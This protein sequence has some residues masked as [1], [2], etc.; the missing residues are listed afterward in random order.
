MELARIEAFLDAYFEGQSTLEQE[1]QLREYFTTQEVAP[2]LIA[3]I[4]LFEGLKAAQEEVLEK[5]VT[6]PSTTTFSKR[7]WLSIAASIVIV[8]GVAGL[9]FSNSNQLTEEEVIALAE[10]NKSKE[11]LLLLSKS[12][13]KGTAEL[14]ALGEFTEAKNKIIK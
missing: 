6:L 10:F 14:A 2:H 4:G 13:N 8:L 9:Q 12:F 5:E 11:I 1:S 7:S 3:Y